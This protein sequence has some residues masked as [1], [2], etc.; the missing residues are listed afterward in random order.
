MCVEC[1]RIILMFVLINTILIIE[2]ITRILSNIHR[3]GR[4]LVMYIYSIYY[5]NFNPLAY[6][7]S[8]NNFL[9]I[10]HFEH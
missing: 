6:V 8:S 1:L 3:C 2:Y 4:V 9:I 10:P 5:A 7:K